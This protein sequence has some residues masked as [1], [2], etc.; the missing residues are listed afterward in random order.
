MIWLQVVQVVEPDGLSFWVY[1]CVV[2][3]ILG[4]YSFIGAV[5]EELAQFT[6]QNK[7]IGY[8]WPVVL[9]ALLGA[10]AVKRVKSKKSNLPKAKVV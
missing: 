5:T 10:A 3:G 4:G 6:D 7:G 8:L 1:L 2:F 9:P